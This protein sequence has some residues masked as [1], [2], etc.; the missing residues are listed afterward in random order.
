MR[1]SRANAAFWS[2][3]LFALLWCYFNAYDD[4]SSIFYNSDLAFTPTF[5]AL[6]QSEVDLYLEENAQNPRPVTSP[7]TKENEFL[8]IGIP[9]VNRTSS[10]FLTYTIGS[11]IDNL[12]P[13]ERD[14]IHIVVLLADSNP[15]QHF[16]YGKHWLSRMADEVLVYDHDGSSSSSAPEHSKNSA[17]PEPEDAYRVIPHDVRGAGRGDG[18]VE[19]MRLDHS[20]L[21]ETCRKREADYFALIEDD[22]IASRDWYA[23]LRAGIGEVHARTVQK[24]STNDWLYLRLFYS[25]IFMGWNNEEVFDYMQ[26]IVLLYGA[27]I[28][29]LALAMFYRRRRFRRAH[30]KQSAPVTSSVSPHGFGYTAALVLGLW[31]P[32]CIVLVFL[33]GRITMHRLQFWRPSVRP[34][35]RYGCCA[36]GMIFPRRH[37]DGLQVLFREPPYDFP[38]DMIL[39][40]YAGDRGLTRWALDPSVLQHIGFI[41]SS[42]TGGDGPRKAEVWNFSFERYQ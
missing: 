6:R 34:M 22:V 42:D 3:W 21:V 15:R 35:Q 29:V 30:A 40:G 9:S 12:T 39:E 4:P 36:Q 17:S 1:I 26:T 31:T 14:S 20:V 2:V 18:R 28:A 7:N 32:A 8:C 41:E 38:G 13:Q 5:S 11:L 10:S 37:L 23:R 19:N 33:A 16:A 24:A 25:E 27:L